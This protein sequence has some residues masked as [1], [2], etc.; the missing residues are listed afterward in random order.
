[1]KHSRSNKPVVKKIRNRTI[2]SF[3]VFILFLT[4][5]IIFVSWIFDRPRDNNAYRPLR[6]VLDRNEKIF[7]RIFSNTHLSK[8]YPV[9]MAAQNVRVNGNIGLESSIDTA[10]W[11]LQLIRYP[12]DTLYIT[13]DEI[14]SLPKKDIVFNFK[15]IEGWSQISHWGGVPFTDFMAAYDLDNQTEMGYVGLHTPDNEYYVGIDM[16]SMLHPQ[17]LLCYEMNGAPLPMNQ[18]APLRLIIPVKYGVK[19]I[20]RIGA[21]YFSNERPP[22]YW[23]ERGYDYYCGL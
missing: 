11:K 7:S 16:E 19:H 2:L 22:D 6:K 9:E 1:M 4:I 17:T 23:Y 3:I 14:K 13:L 5:C 18:G 12:G 15:C 8:T 20:K 10:D 21:L